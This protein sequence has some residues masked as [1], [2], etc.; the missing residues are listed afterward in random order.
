VTDARIHS[1]A[2]ITP[3]KSAMFVACTVSHTAQRSRW[4]MRRG[5]RVGGTLDLTTK[6]RPEVVNVQ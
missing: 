3:R 4:S 6:L 1:G 5:E 2:T